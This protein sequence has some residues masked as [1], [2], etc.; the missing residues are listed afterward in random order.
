MFKANFVTKPLARLKYEP[1][2]EELRW[3]EH[4]T[5][6]MR[7]HHNEQTLAGYVYNNSFRRVKKLAQLQLTSYLYGK[8]N[9]T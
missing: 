4:D 8:L 9:K 6:T 5:R 2:L 3:A 7:S 1:S